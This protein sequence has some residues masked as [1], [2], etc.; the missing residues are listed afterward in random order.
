MRHWVVLMLFLLALGT[1]RMVGC[2][3]YEDEGCELYPCEDVVCP[4]DDN[5]CT[6]EYCSDGDC[7]SKPVED[8]KPCTGHGLS[9]VCVNGVCGENLCE[10]V[11]CD[12]GDAC[13]EGTCD[14]VD[15]KCD[16]AVVVCDDQ[17]ECTKN[18]CDSVD[19][20]IFPTAEDGTRCGDPRPYFEKM[21]EAGVCVM[22]CDPTTEEIYPCPIKDLAFLVCCPGSEYC[23][24]VEAFEVQP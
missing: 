9:G 15:G 20:C 16:F 10:G 12:D 21:C 1:L 17:D 23:C 24:D 11:A 22:P 8:G 5:E 7:R 18:R 19:G 3:D 14:Y 13:T 6:V 4:P 2:G